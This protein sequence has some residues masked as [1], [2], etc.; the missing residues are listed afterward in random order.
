M[1]L[2]PSLFCGM[3]MIGLPITTKLLGVLP[4][5]P[6]F[7]ILWALEGF[8][9]FGNKGSIGNAIWA[10]LGIA[11]QF[12]LSQQLIL[13]FAPFALLAGIVTLHQQHFG[14]K[15]VIT[16]SCVGLGTI[17][18]CVWFAWKPLHIHQDQ[19]FTR[20]DQVVQAL[21]AHPRD[22]LTRPGTSLFGFPPREEYDR[23]T[24]GLFPG[25]CVLILSSVGIAYGLRTSEQKR[26]IMY[27]LL[28]GGTG[29]TLSFGL[30][31][32]LGGWHPFNILRTLIP[33]FHEFRS[34]FRFA[35]LFQMSLCLF[36]AF[37]AWKLWPSQSV[38][39]SGVV[40]FIVGLMAILENLAVPQ[41]LLSY[42]AI[43]KQ[44][45]VSWLKQEETYRIILHVP[46]PNGQHVSDYEIETIRML[47]QFHHRKRL[48]NGYSG[49]FPAGYSN[50]Q[51]DMAKN[52]PSTPLV[53]FLSQELKV[54]A[55]IIDKIWAIEHQR[56]LQAF[57]PFTK[58][59]YEDPH[60]LIFSLPK[61]YSGC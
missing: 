12:F 42:P 16:L 50:F 9:R 40:F 21:S 11:V 49:Y 41:P 18:I 45:W 57:S 14:Q 7:G 60:V 31:L 23:D 29:L 22:Y 54:D 37:G 27:F 20:T 15:P 36:S 19:G 28:V 43:E 34:P 2:W 47:A 55:V 8:V 61:D 30:N 24:G 58:P 52:F 5:I 53:C 17:L 56:Q 48:A 13:L 39:K 1:P 26:W 35:I 33:G 4:L 51:I 59:L 46:F 32:S 38:I 6:L 44:E 25:L 10:G 3:V